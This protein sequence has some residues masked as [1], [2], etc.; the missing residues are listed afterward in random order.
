MLK[1]LLFA[2]DLR[3]LG[4]R[5]IVGK[6]FF[7]LS[8]SRDLHFP[9]LGL[10]KSDFLDFYDKSDVCTRFGKGR[11]QY[12]TLEVLWEPK[13]AKRCFSQWNSDGVEDE[14]AC[15]NRFLYHSSEKCAFPKFGV[16]KARLLD[17]L[18]QNLNFTVSS[19][20]K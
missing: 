4:G 17:F 6:L 11:S 3:G 15:K 20:L 19:E 10:Q 2:I 7:A 1:T 14:F 18:R 8:V 5:I 13:A 12:L 16:A 9:A